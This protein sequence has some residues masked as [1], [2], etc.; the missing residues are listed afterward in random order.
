MAY[1][2]TQL[3]INLMN[4]TATVVLRDKATNSNVHAM[5]KIETPGNQPE[6]RLKELAREAAKRAFQGAI[7]AL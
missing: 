7:D 6:N 4:D 3:N 1:E 5:I 2:V